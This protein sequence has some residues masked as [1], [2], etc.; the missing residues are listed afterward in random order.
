MKMNMD[1][2]TQELIDA[3]VKKALPVL[4]FPSIQLL[5]ITVRDL[6]SD[7]DVQAR[8]MKAIADRTPK[9]ARSA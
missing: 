6:I 4:S 9:A 8:G 5:G 1:Q 3:K 2:W 7:S